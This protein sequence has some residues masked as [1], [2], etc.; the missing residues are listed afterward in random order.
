MNHFQ[1]GRAFCPFYQGDADNCVLCGNPGSDDPIRL[2]FP[3]KTA[4]TRH[5]TTVCGSYYYAQRCPMAREY[6][7]RYEQQARRLCLERLVLSRRE[8]AAQAGKR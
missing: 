3:G 1:G 8:A 2:T 7:L 4:L 6:A 5:L